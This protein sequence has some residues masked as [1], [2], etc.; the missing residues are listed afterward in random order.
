MKGVEEENVAQTVDLAG[1]R[2]CY[3]GSRNVLWSEASFKL[4][5]YQTLVNFLN[6]RGCVSFQKVRRY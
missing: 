1:P 2:L 4:T 5:V 3:V 6:L